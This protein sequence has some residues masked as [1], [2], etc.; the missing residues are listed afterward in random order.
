MYVLSQATVSV[1]NVLKLKEIRVSLAIFSLADD[2]QGAYSV[3]VLRKGGNVSCRTSTY[4]CKPT[5]I[6]NL[7]AE[8]FFIL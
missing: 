4:F 6:G 3:S 8:P 2:F 5:A 1:I 7:G